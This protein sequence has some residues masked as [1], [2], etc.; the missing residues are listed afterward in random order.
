[1]PRQS[2]LVYRYYRADLASGAVSQ[3]D[4]NEVNLETHLHFRP[5]RLERDT[6]R[7][8]L[9]HLRG[10]EFN[11]A[12]SRRSGTTRVFRHGVFVGSTPMSERNRIRTASVLHPCHHRSRARLGGHQFSVGFGSSPIACV[13]E[14]LGVLVESGAVIIEM[15]ARPCSSSARS[16]TRLNGRADGLQKSED[17]LYTSSPPPDA[18]R[19]LS[20]PT[21]CSRLRIATPRYSVGPTCSSFLPA[22]G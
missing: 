21:A 22:C 2:A 17:I 6:L 16:P 4:L 20:S 14:L 18:P 13:L 9:R 5:A 19:A 3:P 1:M 7:I 8:E 10:M 15:H 11:S 12:S